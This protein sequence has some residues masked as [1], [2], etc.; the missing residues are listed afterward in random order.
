MIESLWQSRFNEAS[1]NPCNVINGQAVDSTGDRE[2]RKFSPRDGSLLYGLGCGTAEDVNLAV[3]HARASFDDGRWRR[4]S[5][6][7]RKS[8]LQ[9][10]VALI[11]SNRDQLA[12]YECLDVG[13]P[14]THAVNEDIPAAIH[15]LTSYIENMDK[16]RSPCGGD[17]GDFAYQLR[18]PVGVV[19]GI[20]GWNYPLLTALLKMGPALAMGNSLILKPSEFSALS[21]SRLA[22]L[23][24]EAG[25]PA[26]VFNVVQGSGQVVGDAL[27]LHPDIDLLSFTGS[28]A[29]GKQLM[30]SAGQSNM[31]RLMLECGGKSP[32]IVFDDCPDDLDFIAC[33]IVG[34]AFRNQGE[35]CSAG[36]RL[37]IQESLKER[38]LPKIQEQAGKLIPQDPLDPATQFGALI[39][40]AHINKVLAFIESGKQSDAQLIQGGNPVQVNIAGVS[41]QGYYLEPTIF[42]QVD[43]Y[44]A[45][46]QEEV[47]GP[48]LS[49][50]TFANE[51][52]AIAMA[53]NSCYGLAA[54]A[55]T[56][57]LARAQRLAQNINSGY[58]E[59]IGS[60]TFSGGHVEISS[61]P[62]RQSGMG[63]EVGM[64]GL[65]SYSLTTTAHV[66]T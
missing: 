42:D 11:E 36:S 39:S 50:F 27:A 40:E 29:T 48:V 16:L 33:Q 59:I 14:I 63:P 2:V 4:Q 61:E 44:Q 35:W 6:H 9:S 12:L 54:Y 7:Q 13:K 24:L 62:Q 58:L 34:R 3:K 1:F 22:M 5:V 19:A 49:I 31:K 52:E 25:V 65:E 17:G 43:Q 28:S 38:L 18:K 60:S 46:A 41:S 30:V 8:V 57:D 51:G 55:A 15:F 26:G 20:I 53:N 37:L 45:L 32:F 10:L 66:F 56:T 47:F 64:E 21:A 23:A